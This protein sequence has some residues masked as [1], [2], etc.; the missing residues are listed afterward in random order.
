M[1]DN[2]NDGHY[3]PSGDLPPDLPAIEC[4]LW[5]GE[6]G[7]SA[8]LAGGCLACHDE[9]PSAD[10]PIAGYGDVH[11]FQNFNCD[12]CHQVHFGLNFRDCEGCHGIDSLHNIQA[13]SNGD[14]EIIPGGE[15]PGWGH[16]GN[17]IDCEGCHYVPAPASTTLSDAA[18]AAT[19]PRRSCAW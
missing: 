16:I 4:K 17:E 10:P 11:H 13:D 2:P 14:G 19:T 15:D 3:I 7:A 18:A 5:E 9:D 12:V 1:V 8:C 6:P